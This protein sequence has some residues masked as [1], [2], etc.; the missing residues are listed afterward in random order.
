MSVDYSKVR[1]KNGF[2]DLMYLLEKKNLGDKTS[3]ME[4]LNACCA[5]TEG[6]PCAEADKVKQADK[7]K[8]QRELMNFSKK[9]IED[10]GKNAELLLKSLN[11]IFGDQSYDANLL[12]NDILRTWGDEVV[13]E[14]VKRP[15]TTAV[16]ST[17]ALHLLQTLG[18]EESKI[19][20][21]QETVSQIAETADLTAKGMARPRG[22]QPVAF[23]QAIGLM[24]AAWRLYF[25]KEPSGNPGCL[26]SWYMGELANKEWMP[27]ISESPIRRLLQTP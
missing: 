5:A 19:V 8:G 24:A 2:N 18:L 23:D 25:N 14:E 27:A 11:A 1:A 22:Q 26:F 7:I 4:F 17:A 3:R 16:Q 13:T 6:D 20:E 9:K 12:R 10:L 21:W 15:L